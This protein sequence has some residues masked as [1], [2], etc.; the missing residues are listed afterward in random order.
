MSAAEASRNRGQ[1]TK[2]RRK[3]GG[4]RRGTPNRATRA[5]K[6]FLAEIIDSADVQGAIRS[7]ILKGDTTAFFRALEIVHGKPRQP[8]ELGQDR[9]TELVFRWKDD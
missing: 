4:R 3:T 6:E 8:V 7:R 1:F 9:P 2:G 5:V